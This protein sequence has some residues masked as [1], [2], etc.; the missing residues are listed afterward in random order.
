MLE[1]S[2]KRQLKRNAST[3]S[4]TK[5]TFP[6]IFQFHKKHSKTSTHMSIS[7]DVKALWPSKIRDRQEGYKIWIEDPKRPPRV[8]PWPR[9]RSAEDLH[10]AAVKVSPLLPP[11]SGERRRE[12]ERTLLWFLNCFL[13]PHKKK[14]DFSLVSFSENENSARGSDY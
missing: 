4:Q 12:S 2:V 10:D 13:L 6:H 7:E 1:H 5:A 9:P 11:S 8:S 14:Q 3:L